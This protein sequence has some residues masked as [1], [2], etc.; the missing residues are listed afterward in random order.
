MASN[1][2]KK[3]PALKIDFIQQAKINAIKA[4]GGFVH[5]VPVSQDAKDKKEWMTAH[6]KGIPQNKRLNEGLLAHE[7]RQMA[8]GIFYATLAL[9]DAVQAVRYEEDKKHGIVLVVANSDSKTQEEQPEWVATATS[10]TCPNDGSWIARFWAVAYIVD[11]TVVAVAPFNPAWGKDKH[12]IAVKMLDVA[13]LSDDPK[14]YLLKLANEFYVLNEDFATAWDKA[15]A[16]T[17]NNTAAVVAPVV[18]TKTGEVPMTEA[19]MAAAY[20]KMQE[21]TPK[22]RARVRS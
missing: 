4:N 15:Q 20:M 21:Q 14:A 3:L 2:R 11:G 8:R 1:N 22:V 18:D 9:D 13:L 7:Q 16:R 10:C 12:E 17:K 5:F 19:E 6:W